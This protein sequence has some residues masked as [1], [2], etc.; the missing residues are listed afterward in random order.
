MLFRS[1]ASLQEADVLD[2]LA[3]DT[4]RW[5]LILA[6]DMLC[7]FGALEALLP[8][9]RSRL[10]PAGWFAFSVEAGV[11]EGWALQRQGR[12]VHSRTYLEDA[13]QAAGLAVRSIRP[14]A[15]RLEAGAPVAGFLIVAHPAPAVH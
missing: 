4:Q 9:I 14:Q 1:Y 5:D 3:E 10:A 11:T 13:L 7:Y 8:A 12:Y 2:W 6:G 15:I